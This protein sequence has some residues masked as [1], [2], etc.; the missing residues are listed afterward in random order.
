MSNDI[1]KIIKHK[2]EERGW[3]I[4]KLAKLSGVPQ[5]SIHSWTTGREPKLSQL[6]KVAEALEMPFY[7][8]AF[9]EADPFDVESKILLRE[10]FSGDVRVTLHKIER[11][12]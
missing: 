1:G 6:R 9:G 10:L 12:K 8:L 7:E 5:A 3:P 2:C 11:E 4:T